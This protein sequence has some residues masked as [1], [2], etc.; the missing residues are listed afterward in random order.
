MLLESGEPQ[1]AC[2]STDRQRQ[3]GP[4]A[5]RIAVLRPLGT[6]RTAAA[7]GVTGANFAAPAQVGCWH[8]AA[9]AL[10]GVTSGAGES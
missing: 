7:V 1:A 6:T 4:W 5:G 8:I 10:R 9:E 3:R 2:V